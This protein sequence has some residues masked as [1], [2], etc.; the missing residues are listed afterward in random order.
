M[1]NFIEENGC[2]ICF[3]WPNI[4]FSKTANNHLF[5]EKRLK[6]ICV[7]YTVGNIV[8]TLL[9][10][11]VCFKRRPLKQFYSAAQCVRQS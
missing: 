5:R 1:R 7:L 11:P 10:S 3:Y 4:I 9:L 2:N 8:I 6:K